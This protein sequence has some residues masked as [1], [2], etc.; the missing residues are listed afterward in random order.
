LHTK[1]GAVE[2]THLL[3]TSYG[4]HCLITCQISGSMLGQPVWRQRLVAHDG[5]VLKLAGLNTGDLR[6]SP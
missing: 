5:K 6:S 2:Y 4:N 1:P 3:I